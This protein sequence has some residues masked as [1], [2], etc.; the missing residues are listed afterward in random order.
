MQNTKIIAE[1][2]DNVTAIKLLAEAFEEVSVI[3]MQRVRGNV[4]QTREYLEK[5]SEV[6]VDVKST[7]KKEIATYIKNKKSFLK[8]KS[9]ANFSTFAKNG[10]TVVVLLSANSKFYGSITERVYSLFINTIRNKEFDI[11]I[12]GRLGKEM[13]D[14]REGVSGGGSRPYTYFHIPDLDFN[15]TDL[16]PVIDVV[17]QY[18]HVQ[19]FYGKFYNMIT[20]LPT[21]SS[22]SGD[23]ALIEDSAGQNMQRKETQFHFEP[24]LENVLNL[25]ESQV[26]TALFKQ[27]VHEAE[28]ARLA[29]RITAMES[30]LSSIAVVETS[31]KTDLRRI[32]HA[33]QNSK[34]I[35]AFSGMR[36]WGK[37]N[38]YE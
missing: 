14:G 2:I 25:F 16:A 24:T 3:R 26:F 10:K 23:Q 33:V 34:Q 32:K 1:E 15:A 18:E 30:A 31:L 13:Y 8:K 37:R 27:T 17:L 6:F 29:S 4:L 35:E 20:Q 9:V 38:T 22:V 36:L 11:V 19:V 21:S 28:L 12:V 5:L 7:Y